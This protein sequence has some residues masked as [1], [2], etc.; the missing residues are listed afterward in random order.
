MRKTGI[1]ILI[2]IAIVFASLGAIG[3]E[4]ENSLSS[5]VVSA[6]NLDVDG[7]E[8]FDAL[9]DGLLILR[10]MFGL[11]GAPLVSGAVSSNALYTNA[12]DIEARILS[13]GNRLD[14]DNNGNVDALTD[15]LIILRY[16]FGL[17]GDF[18]TNGVVA[19]DAERVTAAAIEEYVTILATLNIPPV[20][21]SSATFTAAENQTAI[22][23]V[24]A[25]DADGDAVT[26]IVSGSEL[27]ITS[28]GV[29]TVAS[30]PDYETKSS[31]T[32]TVTASDGTNSTTQ[33]ITVTIL[34]I[35]EEINTS[36]SCEQ[37]SQY[38][39]SNE[40]RYCWEEDQTT[41]G[42]DYSANVISPLIVTFD[43][44]SVTI[45]DSNYAE[46]LYIEYGIILSSN[47]DIIWD[48]EKAY[49]IHQMMKKIPQ[50]V[51]SAEHDNR[52]F[53]KWTLT[54]SLL[55]DDIQITE[56]SDA[57]KLVNISSV[58]F[59]N[60]NPRVAAIEG[61]KGIYFS[62]RL[63]NAIVRFVTGNGTDSTAVNKIL[64]DRY[65][66]SLTPP[67]YPDLT[68]N[69]TN[70]TSSRFQEFQALELVAIINMFEEMPSGFHKIQGLNYLVRRVN[71][72]EHPLYADAPAVAWSGAGYIEF[73]ESSFKT[74]DLEYMHRLIIHE[75]AHFLY[76][77]VFD[78]TLL[79]DWA[80]LGG[81][82]HAS[83]DSANNF[84]NVSGWT[85]SK[86]T[87]FVSAYAH[88]KNPNEDMAESI[89]YFIINPD[90]LRSRAE[91]K[92]EFVRDRIMQGDIYISQIQDSLTFTV[93][94][95]YPD[96]VFPGKVN[97]IQI[98]VEGDPGQDKTIKVEIRLHALDNVLEGAK[99]GYVRIASEAK[100]FFDLYLYPTDGSSLGT[101]LL[102]SYTLSKYAKSGYW[103]ASNLILTDQSGNQRM[104]RAG[105][106]FGWRMYV[107]NPK[108]DLIPPKYV[109]NSISLTKTIREIENQP[110][111]VVVGQ[112][113]IE[114]AN[115][116][117]NQGCYGALNDEVSTTYSY[118]KYSPQQYSGDY[119]PNKCYVEYVL[120][121]YMPTGKYRLNYIKQTDAA[122]NRSTNN[123]KVPEG[124]DGGEW[125][126]G[127][128]VNGQLD[129][130][131][132]EVIITTTSPDTA[133]PELDLNIISIAA[134][135]TNPDNPNGETIV[136]FKFRVKD[137]ISG[138]KVGYYKFRDPQGLST[139]YYHYPD[140]GSS[141]FPTDYD[142]DWYEYTSTVI[143]P[144]GSAPGQWGVTELTLRDRAFN[145]KS[146]DFT[147]IVRFDVTE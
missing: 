87:E 63:H 55:T 110:V 103:Q 1:N 51:K 65:G 16:L 37:F 97:K 19:S 4:S 115:P 67:S 128:G 106:D 26:F 72:A 7:N 17:T 35:E 88:S 86:Q 45:P 20:F 12:E 91:K 24:T 146:Y 104:E 102:G 64:N 139:G 145:F 101:Q 40:F 92:Y 59:T 79:G 69:T 98:S 27:A 47:G 123:F 85:T 41:S 135:P 124:I 38:A 43:N 116:E 96:Y 61:K 5:S 78:A 118:E 105:N 39:R 70:E 31:Y 117:E 6:K 83:G 131:A 132:P 34:N 113:Q 57:S 121:Y 75:K 129:E 100:T 119:Q 81:W 77:K 71:G 90:L 18:L 93:Y 23:T 11:T 80:E 29:L 73:M 95:L 109:A 82:S 54:G 8:E 56:N 48:N 125:P 32:A 58:A 3:S 99:Y 10:S 94:N 74:F 21:T 133:A 53:S 126:G 143:L 50:Y 137:D 2:A 66:V 49:A 44:E 60:A 9:T 76:S 134:T 112:W 127:E 144:V 52:A 120:P 30:A 13:L 138:Y 89:S 142:T 84:Y 22:G 42:T 36:S 136:E 33:S 108:E 141:I 68:S 147:E 111:D 28:A 107:N 62:N 14:V 122:L 114:E 130:N 25:T 140:G 46:Q 15:G